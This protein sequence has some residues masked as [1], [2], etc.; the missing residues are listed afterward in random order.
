MRPT[1]RARVFINPSITQR[2]RSRLVP[3]SREDRPELVTNVRENCRFT[4]GKLESADASPNL[5]VKKNSSRLACVLEPRIHLL[6][7]FRTFSRTSLCK[8]RIPATYSYPIYSD[9]APEGLGEGRDSILGCLVGFD[10]VNGFET[11]VGKSYAFG[12]QRK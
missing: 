1:A 3:E 9:D 10:R 8:G 5:A 2:L 11:N 6:C 7:A 12:F 4:W